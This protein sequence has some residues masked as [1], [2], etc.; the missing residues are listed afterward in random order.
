MYIFDR[1]DLRNNEKLFLISKEIFNDN[2]SNYEI[3]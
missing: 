3:A 1:A 2:F